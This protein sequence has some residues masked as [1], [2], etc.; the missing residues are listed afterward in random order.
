MKSVFLRIKNKPLSLPND[1]NKPDNTL[2]NTHLTT[3]TFST[4][5][6]K[7]P[8]TTLTTSTP[9]PT[10]PDFDL[11]KNLPEPEESTTSSTSSTT[12]SNSSSTKSTFT[13]TKT[14]NIPSKTTSSEPLKQPKQASENNPGQALDNLGCLDNFGREQAKKGYEQPKCTTLLKIKMATINEIEVKL[15]KLKNLLE[16]QNNILKIDNN[17]LSNANKN[18]QQNIL[19]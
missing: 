2:T 1:K 12:T 3:N 6:T 15:L 8:S 17:T 18:L 10:Q 9:K 14:D 7:I 5:T 11:P 13:P 16:L 4:K 19:L